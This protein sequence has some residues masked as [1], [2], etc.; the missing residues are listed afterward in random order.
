MKTTFVSEIF[1]KNFH[2][3]NVKSKR[4]STGPLSTEQKKYDWNREG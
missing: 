2:T 3:G 1:G 4:I